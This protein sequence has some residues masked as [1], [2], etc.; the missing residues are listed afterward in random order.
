MGNEELQQ[1]LMEA[2]KPLNVIAYSNCC[3]Y[4]CTGS[5]DEDDCDFRVREQGIYYIKLYLN[6]MNY[7]PNPTQTYIQYSDHG[8]LMANWEAEKNMLVM[9][10]SILGLEQGQY[11]IKKPASEMECIEI[12][13]SQPLTLDPF[14]E[15]PEEDEE[16]EQEEQE[17][18]DQNAINNLNNA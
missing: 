3:R 17:E 11:Q 6:G 12:H 4:G 14:D 8:Y 1:K 18:V 9:W 10:C 16:E 5:Y 2:F 15:D 7:D 13:Y